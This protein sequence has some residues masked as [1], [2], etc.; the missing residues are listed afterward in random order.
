MLTPSFAVCAI[1]VEINMLC[2]VLTSL[3]NA[4]SI[5]PLCPADDEHATHAMLAATG[6]HPFGWRSPRALDQR[7]RTCDLAREYGPAR[8]PTQPGPLPLRKPWLC[9]LC[10]NSTS[11]QQPQRPATRP[12]LWADPLRNHRRAAGGARHRVGAGPRDRARGEP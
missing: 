9:A 6:E 12:R 7:A 5:S 11:C 10:R 1:A 8:Q 3:R 2:N 4:A